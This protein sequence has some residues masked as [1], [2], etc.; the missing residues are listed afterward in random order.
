MGYEKILIV[1][2]FVSDTGISMKALRKLAGLFQE[3]NITYGEELLTNRPDAKKRYDEVVDRIKEVAFDKLKNK[4]GFEDEVIEKI[5]SLMM[6]TNKIEDIYVIDGMVLSKLKKTELVKEG[7]ELAKLNDELMSLKTNALYSASN[8][9]FNNIDSDAFNSIE[10]ENFKSL[11]V[12]SLNGLVKPFIKSLD[13]NFKYDDEAVI[14]IRD[15]VIY[16]VDNLNIYLNNTLKGILSDNAGVQK[17]KVI[18]TYNDLVLYFELKRRDDYII[19]SQNE[20]K[21]N[22]I[23]EMLNNNTKELKK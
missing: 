12:E 8:G 9:V 3:A 10:N 18:V 2:G 13:S 15:K 14:A 5:I 17:T 11:L 16:M 21:I 23:S 20:Y 4:L 1:L 7:S 19:I 6:L 22:V